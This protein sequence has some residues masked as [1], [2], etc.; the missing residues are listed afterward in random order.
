MHTDS[1][2]RFEAAPSTA[3]WL[4]SSERSI[5][6]GMGDHVIG[7]GSDA[8]ISIA[9]DPRLSRRHARLVVTATSVEIE[10]LGSTNGTWVQ[11]DLVQH[12][13]EVPPG[14]HITLGSQVF[15]LRRSLPQRRPELVLTAPE[16]HKPEAAEA[17][18]RPTDDF[19]APDRLAH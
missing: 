16:L 1:T 18:D 4:V 2:P 7:R 14:A 3:F 9:E 19:G 11:R 15:Q 10:D 8:D 13:M 12:P 5:A 17:S 6:L